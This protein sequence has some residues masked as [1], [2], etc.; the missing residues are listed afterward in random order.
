MKRFMLVAVAGLCVAL[1]A[2]AE[3]RPIRNTIKAVQE[4]RA[5]RKAARSVT[6]CQPAP[7]AVAAAPVQKLGIPNLTVVGESLVPSCPGGVCP[8]VRNLLGR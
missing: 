8:A 5:E 4:W 6:A 3:F 7:Q 2:K 1:P